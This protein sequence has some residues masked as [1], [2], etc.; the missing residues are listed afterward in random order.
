MALMRWGRAARA[1]QDQ[2][3]A[4]DPRPPRRRLPRLRSVMLPVGLVRR[5]RD[6]AGRAAFRSRASRPRLTERQPRRARARER[7]GLGTA[8]ARASRLR[9][10]IPVGAG[11]GGGS[12]D[13]AAILRAAI[14]GALR[15]A[16]GARLARRRA[17]ARL[18]RAVLSHRHRRAGRRDRRARHRARRAAAVVGRGARARVHVDTGDAYRALA[19][20]ARAHAAGLRPRAGSASLRALEAVQ[21]GDFAAAIAAATNDFEPL[22]AARSTR[23]SRRRCAALRAA[24]A[25]ARDALGFGRRDASRSA[26]R[27]EARELAAALDLAPD[28]RVC[29]SSRSRGRRGV[30]RQAGA[31]ERGRARRRRPRRRVRAA[32]RRSEQSLRARSAASRSSRASSRRCARRRGIARIIVVAPPATHA[33][34]RARARRRAPRRRRADAATASSR[35][36]PARRPT[37][38]C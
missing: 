21:R 17:R 26:P 16:A 36:R 15:S 23:R 18:R 33:R 7:I 27:A 35:A 5:D 29:S 34:R 4:R 30:A 31:R 28:A 25:R 20:P 6:R 13:A 9:K 19:E 11:L 22:I 38:R 1:G 10:H 32:A 3:H 14:A 2:S 24:G 37:S 8:H 12:S